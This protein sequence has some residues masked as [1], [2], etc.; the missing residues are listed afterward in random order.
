MEN[1]E[2]KKQIQQELKKEGYTTKDVSVSVN[3][4]LNLTNIIL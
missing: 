3:D 4:G 2:I 1:K